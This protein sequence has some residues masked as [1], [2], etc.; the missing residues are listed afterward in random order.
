MA[1]CILKVAN[2]LSP[3]GEDW[4]GYRVTI[5][6]PNM[7]GTT[8]FGGSCPSFTKPFFIAEF[9]DY[10]SLEALNRAKPRITRT[11]AKMGFTKVT[12]VKDDSKPKPKPSKRLDRMAE[13]ASALSQVELAQL[14]AQLQAA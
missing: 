3:I 10:E 8:M 12:E 6:T 4:R 7:A 2:V 14:I 1:S 9:G 5:A 13:Q 11:I